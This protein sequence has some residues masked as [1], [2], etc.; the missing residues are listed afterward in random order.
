VGILKGGTAVDA[1]S[2]AT[3]GKTL[4]GTSDVV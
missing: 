2:L 3:A 4:Y 1:G